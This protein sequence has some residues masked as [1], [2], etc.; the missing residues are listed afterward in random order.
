MR[1]FST[2][3]FPLKAAKFFREVFLEFG[4]PPKFAAPFDTIFDDFQC[5]RWQTQQH[6]DG[7]KVYLDGQI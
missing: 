2:Y 6:W 1:R 7:R 3:F 5:L 4:V